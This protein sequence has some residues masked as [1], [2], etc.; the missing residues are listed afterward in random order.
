MVCPRDSFPFPQYLPPFF[1][2]SAA[3]AAAT[4]A[5]YKLANQVIK[6]VFLLLN[7]TS[8]LVTSQEHSF[9][10]K[11]NRDLIDD[12]NCQPV[13]TLPHPEP[14][15]AAIGR[16]MCGVIGHVLHA[17]SLLRKIFIRKVLFKY[18]SVRRTNRG[19][20]IRRR[21]FSKPI[22]FCPIRDSARRWSPGL[23]NFVSALDYHFYFGYSR[24]LGTTF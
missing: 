14:E 20:R 23:M 17:P 9:Q 1:S 13:P 18:G 3:V 10:R 6:A 2:D 5:Y 21:S 12:L 24:N 8:W 16:L 4:A 22:F 7:Q 11:T 19:H 15:C